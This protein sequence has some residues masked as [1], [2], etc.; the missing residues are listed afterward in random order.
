MTADAAAALPASLYTRP[1]AFQRER[2][3]VFASRWLLLARETALEAPGDHVAAT[4]GGWPVFAIAEEADAPGL[5]RR[6][7]FRNVCRHQGLPLFDPG[8]GHCEQIRCRYHGWTYDLA[9]RFV[10]APPKVAPSDPAD[11]RHHLERVG[12]AGFEGLLF[13]HLG[14]A[15]PPLE[16]S[17][18]A[19]GP[20]LAAAGFGALRFEGERATDIDANWKVVVEQSLAACPPD[21]ARTLQWPCTILDAVPGGAVLHQVIARAFQRT[22]IVHHVYAEPGAEARAAKLLAETSRQA[23]ALKTASAAAQAALESGIAP[24]F[25]ESPALAAFRALVRQAHRAP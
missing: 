14:A 25:A 5:V 17:L 16:T 24:A 8:A 18:D 2:R 12:A 13:V 9:G 20:A 3:A 4:L 22:R 23:E 11:P 7:A 21:I 19:L 15:P 1:E 6:G 10:S